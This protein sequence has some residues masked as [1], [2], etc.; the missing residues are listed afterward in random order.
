MNYNNT[1]S[2]VD[3]LP[4][5]PLRDQVYEALRIY[6]HNLGDQQ[7]SHLYDLVLQEVEPPLLEIVMERTDG[8]Q[9]HAADLLGINRGTLRKKLRK[10]ALDKLTLSSK[11]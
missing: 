8:N 1:D 3:L 11:R 10:Y 5:T 6:F 9:T 2:P 7:P 4:A